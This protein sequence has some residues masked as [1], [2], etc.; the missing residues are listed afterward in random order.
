MLY[1]DIVL[2]LMVASVGGQLVDLLD[3]TSMYWLGRVVLTDKWSPGDIILLVFMEMSRWCS[4]VCC[5]V[6]VL[7][8]V[9]VCT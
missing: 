7:V 4:F 2:F 3:S 5:C 8:A 9:C 1:I 6:A